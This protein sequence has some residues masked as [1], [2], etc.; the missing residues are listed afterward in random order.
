MC[1]CGVFKACQGECWCGCTHT[2][3]SYIYWQAGYHAGR[4]EASKDI[5]KMRDVDEA[6]MQ[7]IE[8]SPDLDERY[9]LI[10]RLD[11]ENVAKGSEGMK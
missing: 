3:E 7:E 11:A 6:I 1:G 9:I 5:S 4:L 2:K 10:R 8:S